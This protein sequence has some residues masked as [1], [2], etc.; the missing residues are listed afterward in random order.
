M[1]NRILWIEGFLSRNKNVLIKNLLQF[2]NAR[3]FSKT[4][5]TGIQILVHLKQ[6]QQQQQQQQH[7]SKELCITLKKIL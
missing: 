4:M 3:L 6:Q 7:T 2:C 1:P 5:V